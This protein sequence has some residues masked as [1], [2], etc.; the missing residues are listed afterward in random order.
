MTVI[1]PLHSLLYLFGGLAQPRCCGWRTRQQSMTLQHAIAVAAVAVHI[2]GSL[3][4]YEE[5]SGQHGTSLAQ[6]LRAN[7]SVG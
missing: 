5:P 4:L 1:S 6:Q 7:K 3:Q 2:C